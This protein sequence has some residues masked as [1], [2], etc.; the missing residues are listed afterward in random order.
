MPTSTSMYNTYGR[1][2]LEGSVDLSAAGA[3]TA[4]RGDGV[5]VVKNGTGLYEATF[6]NPFG[7]VL[8]EVIGSGATMRDTAVGT[9]KDTGVVSVTQLADGNIK[10]IFRTVDAAGAD[11][12]EATNVLT[13]DFY[14]VI[15]IRKMGNPL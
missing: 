5:A 11:V 3:V 7:A 15:R 8:N 9:V 6:S 10:I 14:A 12:N 1:L 4:A 13:V 2:E